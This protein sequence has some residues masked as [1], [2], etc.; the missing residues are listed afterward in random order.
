M[1]RYLRRFSIAGI[2]RAAVRRF[3]SGRTTAFAG[4]SASRVARGKAPGWPRASRLDARRL[5]LCGP[6]MF[7]ALSGVSPAVAQAAADLPQRVVSLD[8]CTDWMLAD[9]SL[10]GRVAALSPLNRRYPVAW[11]D[12]SWP[13]HD[14]TLE[15]V[16]QLRPDMVVT[17]QYNAL[18]LRGRL[19]SLGVRVEVLPLPTRLSHLA[20][21][22][23]RLRKWLGLP[24]A[25][26]APRDPL[27][28]PATPR[29]LL[30]LGANGIGTGRETF[31]DDVLTYAGW[32]NYLTA[33]GY[34]RLDLE[35]VAADPPDAVL[36]ASPVSPAL[37]NLYA[38]HPVLRRAVPADHWLST[39]YW[40]WQCPGPWT[41]SL[42]DELHAALRRWEA[43]G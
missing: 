14:G 25:S 33:P 5:A 7:F 9:E 36:W 28:P 16:L 3:A 40:R 20:D 41:W 35:R 8:L 22:E 38:K 1:P 18:Q 30:L 17:G 6:I 2:A 29:R 32:T 31:E 4:A 13:V 43:R 15:G 39:D 34:Q 24:P 21:Y 42:I 10:R 12:Q 11:L 27:P 26:A 37:A 23:S 19:Q